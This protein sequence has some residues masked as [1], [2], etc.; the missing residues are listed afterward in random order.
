MN[1]LVDLDD[2]LNN[3]CEVWVNYLNNRYNLSVHKEEI[4]S[5][6]FHKAYPTL[7]EQQ[8][9][10]PLYEEA[11]YDTLEPNQEAI[12]YLEKLSKK[13]NIFIVTS[14]PY[15]VADYKFKKVLY[16]NFPF[17]PK[18]NIIIT[19]QKH[20]ING[21][22]LIDDCIDNLLNGNYIKFLFTQPHNATLTLPDDITR[23]DNWE[24]IY[25]LLG[26]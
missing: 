2:V 16:N 1:I 6:Y 20:L 5:W 23:V 14:T 13:H 21:D 15:E 9:I 19:K 25:H 17:I 10:S 7:T 26:E 4:T 24:Q 3:L 12:Y 22:V 11:L 18:E 8:V